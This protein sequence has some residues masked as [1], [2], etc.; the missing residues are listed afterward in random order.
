MLNK[1]FQNTRKPEG[2]S[3]QLMVQMM[4]KGHA[5][6]AEWGFS[7]LSLKGKVDA[8]DIGCGGGANVAAM[9]FLFPEGTV[10]GMDYSPVSVAKTSAVNRDAVEAGRC[11]VLLGDAS[12]LPFEP[13][14]FDLVTAFETIYFWPKLGSSFRQIHRALRP[15]GLF[16][17]CNEESD[18][19]DDTWTKR[20]E[21]MTIYGRR[22]LEQLLREAGFHTITADEK[23]GWLCITA[24]S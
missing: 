24:V 19:T 6:L 21:G 22:E 4:N 16:L 7:H 5:S 9:L 20:I 17:L 11:R 1:F 2:L 14:S 13:A 8:L 10:T 3:G 18:P 23:K 15:G 12:S